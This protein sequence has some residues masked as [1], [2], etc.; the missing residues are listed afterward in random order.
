MGFLDSIK[1]AANSAADS[2]RRAQDN[3]AKLVRRAEDGVHQVGEKVSE[4]VGEFRNEASKELNQVKEKA[5]EGLTTLQKELAGKHDSFESVKRTLLGGS[6]AAMIDVG[7]LKKSGS[8]VVGIDEEAIGKELAGKA[9]TEPNDVKKALG[10][11]NS[12]D[13]DDVSEEVAKNLSDDQLKTLGT[14]PDGRALLESMRNELDD[15]PTWPGEQKQIDRIDAALEAGKTASDEIKTKADKLDP[16]P[17]TS[18][19]SPG[20]ET[21][22]RA[23]DKPTKK[24]AE[25]LRQDAQVDDLVTKASDRART[26]PSGLVTDTKSAAKDLDPKHA[27]DLLART[28]DKLIAAG[29]YGEARELLGTLKDV[30]TSEKHNL[31]GRIGGGAGQYDLPKTL[32]NGEPNPAYG[33]KTYFL[34]QTG[35]QGTFADV[36]KTRLSQI[37]Q[38]ERMDKVLPSSVSR[39]LNPYDVTQVRS[40]FDE[41]KKTKPMSEVGKEYSA[42]LSNF[43]VH[44]GGPDTHWA[45]PR[46]KLIEA[47]GLSDVLRGQPRDAAGRM[48]LDCEGQSF[49]T[50]A[51]FG[52]S[53]EVWYTEDKSHIA[54]TVFDP[55]TGTGFHVNTANKAGTVVDLE[56]PPAKTEAQRRARAWT[57]FSSNGEPKGRADSAPPTGGRSERKPEGA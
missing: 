26:D 32:P 43:A 48:I 42:Y 41:L 46:S 1:S 3:A 10:E 34:Q 21:T 17:S 18:V 45:Q 23:G 39:P 22:L 51:I 28:S 53:S 54:A 13:R 47:E 35:V 20:D 12:E 14:S 24:G 52:K 4:K 33:N 27:G 50:G 57:Y 7:A 30:S 19:L 37:D 44:P 31:V 29:K 56:G 40:Y 6:Y 38:L 2:A 9:L 16:N 49:L 15:G 55:K 11:L 8:A 5:K 36:A 25:E